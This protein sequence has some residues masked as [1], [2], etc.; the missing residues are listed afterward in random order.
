MEET[1]NEMALNTARFIMKNPSVGRNAPVFCTI[2]LKVKPNMVEG[3]I[4]SL[5]AA[6]EQ[7]PVGVADATAAEFGFH[8]SP[9]C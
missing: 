2:C 6:V 8:Q 9:V 3:L 1:L 7:L 5:D 4:G